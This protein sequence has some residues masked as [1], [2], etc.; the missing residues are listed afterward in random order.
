MKKFLVILA[1]LMF[2]L[3]VVSACNNNDAPAPAPGQDPVTGDNVTPTPPDTPA[4]PTQQVGRLGDNQGV[5]EP[6]DFGGRTLTIGSWW[7]DPI[8]TWL[9]TEPEPDAMNYA[10][11]RMMWENARRVEREFNVRFDQVQVPSAEFLSNLATSVVAGEPMAD[12]VFLNGTMQLE[13]MGSVIR[14]FNSSAMGDGRGLMGSQDFAGPITLDENGNIWAI[15]YH[16]VIGD[17]FILGVNLD[18][19]DAEGL[20]NP[21]ELYE[22]GEWT[23][24]AMLDIMRRATRDTDGDG[25]IDQF[26]IGGQPGDIAQHL[27]GANDG[28]MVDANL[29]YGFD[30]PHS[31]RALEF[32][33]QIF[34]EQ[35]W[36][37]EAG[38]I[39][40]TSN[41]DRNFF[42]WNREA[43]IVFSPM[44]T[45]GLN[46]VPP[47]FEFAAVPFPMGPDNTSGNTWLTGMRQ[48]ICAV[49]GSSWDI[50]DIVIII[51]EL[52]SWPGDYPGILF[53]A[54]QIDWLR[55][56]FLTPGD[57]SRA[58]QAGL[59]SATDVGRDVAQYYWILGYF[60]EQF[61]NREMDVMQAI[62]YFRGPRQEMLDRRFR[63]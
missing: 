51:D 3:A 33:E 18:I 39:M 12:I 49:V 16:S 28:I 52:F 53:A 32:V 37:P 45:W 63:Q 1:V 31:I 9:W 11:L 29:N 27:I 20:P 6:R 60:V 10:L 50:D 36:S 38:G 5:H 8:G 41:W 47:T 46:D 22:A 43:N 21:V 13:A 58:V 44:V 19:I 34:H 23:W 26:G 2:S 55:E 15:N 48:G 61:W 24:D 57:V 17:A 54:G 40:D 42:A 62:E 30:H 14:P 7:Q 35:L 59:S 56:T 25:V 4:P